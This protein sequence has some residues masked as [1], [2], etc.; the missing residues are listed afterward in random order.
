MRHRL[1]SEMNTIIFIGGMIDLAL[2]FISIMEN[3]DEEG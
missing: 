1:D 2:L 3:N